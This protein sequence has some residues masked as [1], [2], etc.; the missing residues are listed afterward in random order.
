MVKSIESRMVTAVATGQGVGSC[1]MAIGFI[2]QMS[3]G[4]YL[5][6]SLKTLMNYT[7]KNG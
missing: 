7:V 2:L 5:H 1:L 6:N 3:L 4:D